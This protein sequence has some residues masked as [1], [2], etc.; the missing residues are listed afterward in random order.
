MNGLLSLGLNVLLLHGAAIG[1]EAPVFQTTGK[2]LFGIGRV[3][4]VRL[5]FE[6]DAWTALEPTEAKRRPGPEGGPGIGLGPG[7]RPGPEGGPGSGWRPTGNERPPGGPLGLGQGRGPMP[8][9]VERDYPWSRGMVEWDGIRL[10]D[11]AIRYKGNSSFNASR[12]GL[13]RPFKLDIHRGHKGRTLHGAKELWLNNNVNDATQFREALAYEVYRTVGLAAPRTAFARVQLT[14]SGEF[15][16]RILG[17]YTV[18]EAVDRD[19]LKAHF[20]D[21]RGLLVKPERLQGLEYLGDDWAA[22]TNRYDPKG[23][24]TTEDTRRFIDLARLVERA[25]DATFERELPSRLDLPSF[26]KF[27]AVTALLANYD[28]FVGNGH[29]YY[30]FQPAGGRPGVFIPWDLNE[31]FGGHPMAGTR[32]NQAELSVLRPGGTPN[33]L[34][35]R[36]LERP[37][38]AKQYRDLLGKWVTDVCASGRLKARASQLAEVVRE[39]VAAESPEARTAFE[40]IALGE[41]SEA[42]E[43]TPELPRKSGPW[44]REEVPLSEWIERRISN[45]TAELAGQRTG[46]TPRTIRPGEPTLRPGPKPESRD[47]VR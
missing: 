37:A 40:R 13:K 23:S 42:L 10:E 47:P 6:R 20:E 32:A 21:S 41:A 43:A 34:L 5:T 36:V 46:T 9:P 15:T 24:A 39:T 31:A 29:N 14:I 1:A 12:G 26:L 45:V 11:V 27:V 3:I 38:W 35:E 7:R 2:D 8:M 4:K 25:D 22:Y 30:L 28:S 33:R 18:V 16:N 19:F 44:P 17:L